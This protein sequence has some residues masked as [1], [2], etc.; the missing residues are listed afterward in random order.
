MKNHQTWKKDPI[1]KII[2]QSLYNLPTPNSISFIWNIG[3]ILGITLCLQVVT[4]LVLSINYV[5]SRDLAFMSVIHIIRDLDSGWI[6]RY[7]HINGA[8]LFFILLYTHLGRGLYFNSFITTPIV[9]VSGVVIFLCSIATAFIGYVL[10]WGQISFWGATVITRIISAIPYIGPT[11]TQWLWGNF[12]VSQPTLNR[13]YSLHFILPLLI[14]VLV[15]AHLMILHSRGSSNPTSTNP[16][17]DKIKFSPYFL[18]KDINPLIV[19]SIILLILISLNP[20]ILGDVEN[21]NEAR[22][23]TTPTHIQPEWYFLYAYAILRAV[24]SKLGGVILIVLSILCLIPL[25]IKSKKKITPYINKKFSPTR[26]IIYW[27][28]ISIWTILTWIGIKPVEEPYT[29]IGKVF[30]ALYFSIILFI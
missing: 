14:I 30:S 19:I 21:F 26:K 5:A 15:I 22:P 7:L 12:S 11:V 28:I 29:I 17:L 6:I 9:W 23:L 4:G 10:P 20:N 18:V 24:P 25:I 16:N 1:S 27:N 3:F 2:I 8:S 13:F